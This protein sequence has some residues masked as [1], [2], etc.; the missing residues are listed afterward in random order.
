[1]EARFNEPSGLAII[2]KENLKKTYL[3]VADT[4]NNSIR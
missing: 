1:M 4:N 2:Y 3:Y